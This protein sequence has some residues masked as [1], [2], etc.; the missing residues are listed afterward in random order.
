MNF[1]YRFKSVMEA[2]GIKLVKTQYQTPDW[3]TLWRRSLYGIW[4][5]RTV[6]AF[7]S[8]SWLTLDP[9]SL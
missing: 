2:A 7:A 6:S 5:V 9:V 8:K 1:R 4:T 3:P